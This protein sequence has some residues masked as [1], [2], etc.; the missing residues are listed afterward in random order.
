MSIMPVLPAQRI[1]ESLTSTHVDIF[2]A[3]VTKRNVP[4]K[5][6]GRLKA[7]KP[8]KKKLETPNQGLA[9]YVWRMLCFDLVPYAPHCCMPVMADVD[10]HIAHTMREGKAIRF[11]EPG[12]EEFKSAEKV[13]RQEMDD[14]VDQ[15]ESFLRPHD[16]KGIIRWGTALGML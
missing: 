12:Y 2:N 11:G 7:T 16:K 5:T 15:I 3:T 13:L 14:L 10:V 4:D 1:V 8:F 6:F 9:N